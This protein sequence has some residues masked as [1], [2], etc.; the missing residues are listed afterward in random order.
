MIENKLV[1]GVFYTYS[2]GPAFGV[3]RIHKNLFCLVKTTAF[4]YKFGFGI[5]AALFI[6]FRFAQSQPAQSPIQLDIQLLSLRN[7][8]PA[9]VISK[10]NFGK[11]IIFKKC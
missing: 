1:L 4:L 3:N 11:L 8:S 7:A 2:S 10:I 9:G 5:T 6:D